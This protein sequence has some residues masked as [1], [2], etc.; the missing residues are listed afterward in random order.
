MVRV[1]VVGDRCDSL[2]VVLLESDLYTY[3]ALHT[4][5]APVHQTLV[6]IAGN[7]WQLAR[8]TPIILRGICSILRAY[9][10]VPSEKPRKAT[11]RL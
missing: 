2:F 5:S 3:V 11:L 8:L 7:T 1:F 9:R 6:K 4:T 10:I